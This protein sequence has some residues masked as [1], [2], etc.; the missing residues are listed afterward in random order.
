MKP[1]YEESFGR[2]YLELYAHRDDA[3]AHADI[4]AIVDLISPPRDQ[5]LLDLCCG[6]GRHLLSL[7]E[8]G[9]TNLTG[10]DLSQ[11]LLDVAAKILANGGTPVELVRA[12]MRDIPYENRFRT[13][14]SLFTSFGYFEE[15][16]ENQAVF[17]AVR[18]ALVPGGVFLIDYLNSEYVACNLV[19]CDEK[20]L[21]D[22]HIYNVRCL[23]DDCRRVEKTTTVTTKSGRQRV[24]HESVRLYSEQDM[25][26]MLQAEG[27]VNISSC[28]SLG[29]QEF[30]C[31]D[32]ER[33]I[34]IAEKP[35]VSPD[36]G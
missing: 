29:G 9:F 33:L 10:L 30:C 12:D 7:R 35:V 16:R 21:S 11:E 4:Q 6:A 2:E 1:W 22:R 3:E 28:G 13:I 25:L 19:E 14:L 24:F 15:D 36:Q 18:R 27:F 32:S 17:A 26:D 20:T 5:P 8:L 31:T 34:L 23:T